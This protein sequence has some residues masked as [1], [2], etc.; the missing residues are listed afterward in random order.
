MTKNT[1]TTA[2]LFGATLTVALSAPAAGEPLRPLRQAQGK[3]A[4]GKPNVVLFFIDDMGY[5]DIGPYGS[6]INKTPHLDRMAAEGVKFTDFY[7]ASTQC[8]PSRAALMT[9]CYA[10][11]VGMGSRVCFPSKAKALQPGE[12]TMAEMFKDAGYA[13]GCF[14]KWH[15]GHRAG[16]LPNDQGFDVYQGIPYSNDMW[17]PYDARTK[18]WAIKGWRVPLPWL[19]DGT[20]VAV[21]RDAPDQARL[22]QATTTAA[23][24]FIRKQGAK[25][26]PFFAYLPY[27]AVH[28]PRVGHPD[29][30]PPGAPAVKANKTGAEFTVH[31]TAQIEELDWAVGQVFKLLKELKIDDSTLVVFMSDNG[32]SRGTSTGRLKGGKGSVYEGGQRTVFLARWPGTVPAGKTTGEIGISFDLLPTFAKLCGGT[33]SKNTIDGRDISQLLLNPETAHSPHKGVAH[34]GRAYRLGKWKMVGN[35]ELYDLAS[36]I[37]EKV[38]LAKKHPEKLKELVRKNAEWT[39]A[40]QREL[41]PHAEMP[42]PSPLVS[43]KQANAL[44]KL[45]E[46]PGLK[47]APEGRRPL[48]AQPGQTR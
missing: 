28:L 10:E 26:T 7:V 16:Y 11:R 9:G 4:Q 27:A 45:S 14:G 38:N 46:W 15:L 21:V 36:D 39:A 47:R 44:P 19:V 23:L 18:K 5:G 17:A 8:S 43:E 2:I 29:F 25:K 12:Y 24:D 48:K 31:L 37:G 20:P 1:L 32:G 42:D 22:T 13:T 40:M 34:K 33:L 6:K 41:R 35:R 30:L 3:Q